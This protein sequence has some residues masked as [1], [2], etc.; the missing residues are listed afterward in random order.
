M[1]NLI[2]TNPF[3]DIA[4]LFVT[5]VILYTGLLF[6]INLLS[7]SIS[8]YHYVRTEGLM[9]EDIF[10]LF[11]IGRKKSRLTW[12]RMTRSAL[13]FMKRFLKALYILCDQLTYLFEVLSTPRPTKVC[14]LILLLIGIMIKLR[15]HRNRIWARNETQKQLHRCSA[16]LWNNNITATVRIEIIVTAHFDSLIM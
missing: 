16:E 3:T 5:E 8:G 4:V 11:H 13:E 10:S 9:K 7:A 15:L 1:I 6:I 12:N 2:Y 14:K